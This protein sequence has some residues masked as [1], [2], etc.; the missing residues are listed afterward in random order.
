MNRLV[1]FFVVVAAI[2]F[3]SKFLAN[4]TAG[5]NTGPYITIKKNQEIVLGQPKQYPTG[6]VTAL[7]KYFK[8]QPNVE[9]AYLAQIFVESRKEPPHPI[10][11][12]AAQQGFEEIA[13]NAARIAHELGELT[14]F[15]PIQSDE[16]STYMLNKTTPF[17]KKD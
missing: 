6:L 1:V 11:G 5:E 4:K 17:Y 8:T 12:I 10:I 2:Y 9:A 13:P 3:A 7:K 15:V 16:V 14:D